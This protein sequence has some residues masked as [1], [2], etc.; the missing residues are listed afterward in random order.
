MARFSR[1]R[2]SVSALVEYLRKLDQERS[3]LEAIIEY[4]NQADKDHTE[5]ALTT[6]GEIA[7]QRLDAFLSDLEKYSR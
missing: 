6:A 4:L 5:T 7:L 3:R 1:K 2:V